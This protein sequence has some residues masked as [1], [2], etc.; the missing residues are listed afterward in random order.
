MLAPTQ[1]INHVEPYLSFQ[2]QQD[3]QEVVE[4]WAQAPH[5][6]SKHF[7]EAIKERPKD[8]MSKFLT[9]HEQLEDIHTYAWQCLACADNVAIAGKFDGILCRLGL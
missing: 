3:L 6:M 9:G 4:A 2:G 8:F 7:K 5:I 1:Q